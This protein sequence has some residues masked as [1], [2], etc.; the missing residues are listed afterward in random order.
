MRGE[1]IHLQPDVCPGIGVENATI[2][3]LEE[4]TL[5]WMKSPFE[6]NSALLYENHRKIKLVKRFSLL[7]TTLITHILY[8]SFGHFI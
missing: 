1:K 3:L 2:N 5:I 8:V 6:N 4:L 7:L